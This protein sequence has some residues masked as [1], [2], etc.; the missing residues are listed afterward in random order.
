MPCFLLPC[1]YRAPSPLKISC[2][3]LKKHPFMSSEPESAYFFPSVNVFIVPSVKLTVTFLPDWILMAGPSAFV[4]FT[5]FS[6]NINFLS[7]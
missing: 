6:V 5:P 1:T 3:S 2:P 7:L 4:I